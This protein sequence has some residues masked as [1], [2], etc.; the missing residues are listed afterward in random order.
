[1][2]DRGSN[3]RL[4]KSKTHQMKLQI[5]I[6]V[7]F[8]LSINLTGQDKKTNTSDYKMENPMTVKYLEKNLEK[9]SPRL[10][11]NSDS[12][13]ILRGKLKSDPLVQSFYKAIKSDAE[14]IL[15]LHLPERVIPDNKRLLGV[16][17][18]M[19]R[20]LNTL[21]IVYL[22]DKDPVILA[23][24]QKELEAVCNFVDWNPSHYLDVAEMSLAVALA[25]DWAGDGLPESTVELV[26]KA[27]IEKGILPSYKNNQ[28][29]IDGSGNWNQ[30]CHGGLVAA[31]IAIAGR[32]PE[33]AAKTISRALDN[34]NNVLGEYAPHGVYNEGPG[35]WEYGT[36]Y[37]II[38][39]SVLTSAFG[40]DFGLSSFPGFLESARF[41]LL[42]VAPSGEWY[43]FGDNGTNLV[44]DRG[45]GN[46]AAAW[47]NLGGMVNILTWFALKTGNTLFF[48]PSYFKAD[49][50]DPRDR[51]RFAAPALI[52]LSQYKPGKY[53]PLP[54]NWKGDGKNPV[55]VLRGGENN[56]ENNKEMFYLAAK[57][58]QADVNHGSM[59]AGSFIFELDGVRWSIDP[60]VQSYAELELAGIDL[61]NRLQN[62][63]RYSLLTKGSHGHSTLI[64]NESPH[65]VDGNVPIIDF[66]DGSTGE[67]PG[68]T[69]DM[70]KLFTG[71]LESATRKFIKDGSRKLLIED[72]I[73]INNSTSMLTWQMMTT[74]E[75]T[76]VPGG[77]I[78]KQDGKEL[79]LEI[80][81]PENINVSVI[82][83]DPPPL[84]LDKHIENLK[85]IEVR[86]PAWVIAQGEK[87][88]ISLGDI[89]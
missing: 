32:D 43:N 24:I 77:A 74:A 28:S 86:V 20:R 83:L 76:P 84:K 53:N 58:G 19:V 57:G 29:W 6:A 36:S 12:E 45:R 34:M 60:G 37:S 27:L 26:E 14:S 50:E 44:A 38:T 16:S 31:S 56:P 89:K 61:W 59:D 79:K 64:V 21:G 18:E 54:L 4:N 65:I 30:V 75:V 5:L 23:R 1:M 40:T 52:W 22:I 3:Y 51:G 73:V 41:R 11:L 25:L 46:H 42:L 2:G 13:R 66:N 48:D 49:K 7:L 10:I 55:A 71:Q 85:R 33:L 8:A 82:S 72:H 63:E 68:F 69:F 47:F 67:N 9:K 17:R 87:I 80:I 81:S 15:S 35:Y 62:S 88:I 78:L 39:S 70:T